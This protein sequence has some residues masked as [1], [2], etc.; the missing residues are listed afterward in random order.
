MGSSLTGESNI[1]IMGKL[2]YRFC[3]YD[4]VYTPCIPAA[5]YLHHLISAN[6]GH[7]A[8][9][10][11]RIILLLYVQLDLLPFSAR[12]ECLLVCCPLSRREVLLMMAFR[13]CP[14]FSHWR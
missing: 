11:R 6:K 2:V 7:A 8:A 13:L 12:E 1:I 10:E 5:N 3:W 9:G 4:V 14:T